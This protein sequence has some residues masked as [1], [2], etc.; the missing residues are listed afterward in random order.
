M[1]L[2]GAWVHRVYRN[3]KDNYPQ[4]KPNLDFLKVCISL[5]CFTATQHKNYDKKLGLSNLKF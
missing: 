2:E 1:N 4:I 3:N 5:S